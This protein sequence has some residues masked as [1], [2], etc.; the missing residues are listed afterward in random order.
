ME[1]AAGFFFKT[2]AKLSNLC[3]FWHIL[4]KKQSQ[5]GGKISERWNHLN[6]VQHL[7]LDAVEMD[8]VCL[9][10]VASLAQHTNME[11]G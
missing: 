11:V 4:T 2:I 6:A 1:I 9:N 10:D 3:Q 8:Y 5:N 7:Y